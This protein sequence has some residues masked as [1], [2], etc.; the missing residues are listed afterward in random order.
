VRAGLRRAATLVTCAALTACA[1]AH[2]AEAPSSQGLFRADGRRAP[3]LAPGPRAVWYAAAR[4]R[5]FEIGLADW[6][7]T[8]AAG[9]RRLPAWLN[10]LLGRPPAARREA[11]A[12]IDA[13]A[14]LPLPA[15]V[16]VANV[17][18]G[19]AVRVRID[20]SA[21]LRGELI[22][23]PASLARRLGADPDRALL[24]RVRYAA[25]VIAYRDRGALR[26]AWAAPRRGPRATQATSAG[27]QLAATPAP[28]TAL[29]P[30]RAA[31]VTPPQ[32]PLDLLLRGPLPTP[33]AR[34]GPFAVEA[35][36]FADPANARRAAVRLSAAGASR[37]E[38]LRRRGRSLYL[39]VV[40]G[41][42]SAEAAR[43]LRARVAA[44]GFPDAVLRSD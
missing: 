3:E 41:G 15:I 14:K 11:D 32:P 4:P 35:G 16:E 30:L 8:P 37:V 26:V 2:D 39:V 34:T 10:R 44:L 6:R 22:S 31:L 33:A 12:L 42:A 23:L 36:A 13:H 24:V 43:S 17:Q 21:P 27:V 25:P 20:R 7:E 1:I 9:S 19:A 29:R 40:A 18:T 5:Y 28:V 38:L